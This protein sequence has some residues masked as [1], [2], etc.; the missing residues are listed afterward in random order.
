MPSIK[1]LSTQSRPFFL[2]LYLCGG[3]TIAAHENP[4]ALNAAT[5]GRLY[6]Y[7]IETSQPAHFAK[8]GGNTDWIS[9]SPEGVLI[10]KPGENAPP[11]TEITV[12]A[13]WQGLTLR[14]TFVI[15]VGPLEPCVGQGKDFFAWCGP[16]VE[17]ENAQPAPS[18]VESTDTWD[19]GG[20]PNCDTDTGERQDK[21]CRFAFH[22]SEKSVS[23]E[24]CPNGDPVEGCILQFTRLDGKSGMFGHFIRNGVEWNMP[25]VWDSINLSSDKNTV[26]NAINSSKV[27]LSGSVLIRKNVPNCQFW[28][29]TVVT[30]TVDSSNILFY[31][32]SDVSTFCNDNTVLIVLPVHAIWA[33]AYGIP[34]NV[35]DPSWKPAAAPKGHACWSGGKQAPSRGIRP[36]DKEFK[37]GGDEQPPPGDE[38]ESPNPMTSWLYRRW[39]AWNY[40][41]LTQPGVSQGSISFAPIALGIKQTWDV[42]TYESAR[43]GWGWIGLPAMYEFDHTQRDNFNS[44]TA[45]VMYDFRFDDNHQFW[46]ELG[47]GDCKSVGAKMHVKTLPCRMIPPI[48]GVRP[49]EFSVRAGPE[50]APA[51]V[52]HFSGYQT[53]DLNMVAGANLR[54]PIIL[55]PIRQGSLKQP[56]QFTFAPMTGV[57]RGLRVDW[58]M[59]DGAPQPSGILR[60]VA[61]WDA[62]VRSPYNITHNFLGDRPLT[63]DFSYR[64]RWLY[65]KEPFTNEDVGVYGALQKPAESQDSLARSYTRITFIAPFS[66]YLQLRL[67]WQHGS[68]PPAFQFVNSEVTLGLSFSN[69]G[70]SEH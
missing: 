18:P 55:N 9:V 49:L 14:R 43:L 58:H 39:F 61:G 23:A 60:W 41:R 53:R 31:G 20:A 11:E 50:W 29:W 1:C 5:I 22:P 2:L 40:N 24:D 70:S 10:G 57:E 59:I 19:S 62:S 8:V 51:L 4:T 30:Q 3:M 46:L 28:S 56:A 12:E 52:K 42:Q 36:C 35:N 25:V 27:F 54:L 13:S 7:A 26:I 65:E 63:V 47:Q 64:M 44:L 66:A 38:D 17:H 48:L 32:S 16:T 15:P 45:A 34:A 69:P 6:V 21:G 37:N 33:N 68:L 67:S